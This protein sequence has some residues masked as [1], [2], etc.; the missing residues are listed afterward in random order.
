[1]ELQ[2]EKTT[3]SCLQTLLQQIKE[4]E[5]T[6]EVRITEDMPDIGRVLFCWGQVLIRSKEWNERTAG[7]GGGVM[8]RVLYEPEDGS[9]PRSLEAWLPLQ[10]RWDLPEHDRDGELLVFPLI[11]GMDARPA[12]A[13]SMLFR[14]SVSALGEAITRDDIT[15][16]YPDDKP[17]DVECLEHTY[18]VLLGLESGEKVFTMEE[19]V[20]LPDGMIA[21]EKVLSYSAQPV[22][23][24]NRLMG[25]KLVFRG[26]VKLHLMYIDDEGYLHC[27][28]TE[29][30]FSQYAQLNGEYGDQ[31]VSRI[32]MILSGVE[33]QQNTDNEFGWKVTMNAQYKILDRRNLKIMSDAY[34]PY[35]ETE[36]HTETLLVPSVLSNEEILL[37]PECSMPFDGA[38]LVESVCRLDHPSCY[39]QGNTAVIKCGGTF[40]I[41]GYN[42]DGKL[43][44]A[45]KRWEETVDYPV[46]PS[47]K[48]EL[49]CDLSD[50]VNTA[51]SG[52]NVLWSTAVTTNISAVSS[53][54]LPMVTVLKIGD[55]RTLDPER[56]GLVI[57]RAGDDTLWEIARMTGSTVAAIMN[58]NHLEQEPSGDQMLLIPVV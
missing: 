45:E 9:A 31:A 42:A 3:I 19:T 12:S 26:N 39:T 16:F 43:V 21:P 56:P 55:R 51:T 13:R 29:R 27:W 20:V 8:C 14:V 24:E 2:F 32:W 4:Q 58:A 38:R 18:P 46:D 7:V 5:I 37:K 52:G 30:P 28:D 41:L 40:A 15:V 54:G 49:Y 36:A 17:E 1:M 10:I 35:R 47:V 34:S 57:R 23:T 11:R 6:Q 53:K 22:I 48:L 33:M 25:D 44:S 50:A